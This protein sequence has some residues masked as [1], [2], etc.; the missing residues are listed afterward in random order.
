MKVGETSG[1]YY[2]AELFNDVDVDKMTYTTS[3]KKNNNAHPW[4]GK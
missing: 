2:F 1:Q 4:Y 3:D